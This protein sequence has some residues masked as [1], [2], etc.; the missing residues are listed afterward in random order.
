MLFQR[1]RATSS[2][3]LRH[4]S[5]LE[6]FRSSER[7]GEAHVLPLSG[8]SSSAHAI[9][10]LS[11]CK[12]VV[13]R[14]FPRILEASYSPNGM[15]CIFPLTPP[16]GFKINDVVVDSRS[17]VIV[18]GRVDCQI[19]EPEANLFAVIE[20]DPAIADRGWP[21][22]RTGIQFVHADTPSDLQALRGNVAR[23][24]AAASEQPRDAASLETMERQLLCSLDDV[25]LNARST[26]RPPAYFDRYLRIVE[27]I[28]AYQQFHPDADARAGDLA[29]HC[30][31]SART[32]Q[33]ATKSV[34]GMSVHRYLRLRK[35]WSV[36]RTLAVGRPDTVIS[37]V[38]RANGFRHMGEFARA[39]RQAFGETASTTL[40]RG[41][42]RA[43]EVQNPPA[44]VVYDP[45]GLC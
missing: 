19:V 45:A 6:E 10:R 44:T 3:E 29:R 8:Q 15:L 5:T 16:A 36:R 33:N 39:Y 34:R 20:L 25:I 17:V 31:V 24:L 26:L 14:T 22:D 32:L 35:L 2:L 1:L 21:E 30:G 7:L 41:Q 38:A 23:L 12:L 27:Q 28:E 43:S 11:E 42:R 9:V 4:F 40:T 18:R 13:K 37:D